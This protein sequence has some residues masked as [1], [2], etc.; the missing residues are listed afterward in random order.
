MQLI[1]RDVP[2]AKFKALLSPASSEWLLVFHGIN[3]LGKTSLLKYLSTCREPPLTPAWIDFDLKSH[4][5]YYDTVMDVLDA[6]LEGRGLSPKSWSAYEGERDRV[7]EQASR[8]RIVVSQKILAVGGSTISDVSQTMDVHAEEGLARIELQAARECVRVWLDLAQQLD[9]LFVVLIDHWDALVERGSADFRAWVAQDLLLTAHRRLPG[10]R[11]VIASDRPLS[12][13]GLD[14]GTAHVELLPFSPQDARRMMREGGLNAP[15]IQSTI[16]ERTGGNPL[17][18]NLALTLWQQDPGLD[19][20]DL[21]RGLSVR[22][23]SEWLLGR[24]SERLT[25]PRSRDVLERGVILMTWTR[26]VL[27]AVCERDDLDSPWYQTFTAYP[28]VQEAPAQPG[29]KTFIRT[30]REIQIGQLWLNHRPLFH[31]THANALRWYT[32]W[33]GGEGQVW[34]GV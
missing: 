30:V 32:E 11:V 26:D 20:S 28:F 1:D 3:G 6:S 12:E 8:D 14:E 33:G 13:P 23:A 22:A 25:D 9:G 15:H 27:A 10:L 7:A 17:L 16:I 5:D 24:I 21:V 2:V 31:Q 4:R 19:L 29:L 18:L 34:T